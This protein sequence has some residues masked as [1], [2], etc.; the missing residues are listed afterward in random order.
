MKTR[1]VKMS[2]MEFHALRKHFAWKCEYLNGEAILR[3]RELVLV[4]HLP[5]DSVPKPGSPPEGLRKSS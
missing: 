5:L 3:P 2:I 1:R 4:G